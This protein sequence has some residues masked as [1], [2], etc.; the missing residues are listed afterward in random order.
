MATGWRNRR[1]HG[2]DRRHVRAPP[3]Q[4]SVGRA[5]PAG[6]MKRFW[7]EATVEREEGGWSIRLDNR[8]VKTPARKPLAVPS[9]AL[10]EAIAEEWRSVDDQ[11]DPR[12][13]PLTGLA[14]AAI[15]RVAPQREAFASGLSRYAE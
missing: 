9:K 3:P 15:D 10:A 7:K 5:R 11:I 2:S 8:P 1:D 6:R 4:E 14:N 13:M 12:A